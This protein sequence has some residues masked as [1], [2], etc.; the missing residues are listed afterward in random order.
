MNTKKHPSPPVL[1][2]RGVGVRG[3]EPA[4]NIVGQSCAQYMP[5]DRK[6]SS[7]IN[8]INATKHFIITERGIGAI[9]TNEPKRDKSKRT[10]LVV[11]V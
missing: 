9:P 10:G 11:V 8:K 7:T 5:K 6:K 1:R 2:G 4:I 3:A